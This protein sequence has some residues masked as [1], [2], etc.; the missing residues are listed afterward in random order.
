MELLKDIETETNALFRE[1]SDFESPRG[2]N[3][4]F[5]VNET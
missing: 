3:I 4:A 5:F 2:S 1:F